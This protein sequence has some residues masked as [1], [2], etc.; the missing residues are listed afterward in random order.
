MK[1][2]R[3]PIEY[4]D[5]N[6]KSFERFFGEQNFAVWDIET[7]GLSPK[8]EKIILSGIVKVCCEEAYFIQF[9][10]EEPED[11][12]QIIEETLNE[13]KD[14]DFIITFNGK[15]FD[16]PFIKKRYE[17]LTKTKE[18]V[19]LPYNLD[20]YKIIKNYSGLKELLPNLKQKTIEKFMNLAST[21][22]DEIS[23][24]ESAKMYKE[25]LE[26]KD[27]FLEEKILLHNSDDILQLYNL[28]YVI[29]YC[30]FYRAMCDLGFPVKNAGII[31]YIHLKKDELIIEGTLNTPFNYEK[32]SSMGSL[33]ELK[34]NK[35]YRSFYFSITLEDIQDYKIIDILSIDP[36][37]NC[38]TIPGISSGYLI[39]SKKQNINHLS[40]AAFAKEILTY[41]VGL[42]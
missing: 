37:F 40:I 13:F 33:W 24:A 10:A 11:E 14:V 41:I 30:D 36:N 29:G 25:Y 15:Q 34:C 1:T 17:K 38:N 5:I 19:T 20:L 9:L 28:I 18:R 23:G 26:T 16:L 27:S 21:R 22:T 7:T 8:Y 31:N 32:F 35:E 12:Y 42:I 3:K 2:I 6:L 39:V 4:N